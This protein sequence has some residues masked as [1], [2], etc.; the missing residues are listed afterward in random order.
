LA[1]RFTAPD[2][3]AT[4]DR[5]TVSRGVFADGLTTAI[6]GF[7]GTTLVEP[8][9]WTWQFDPVDPRRAELQSSWAV[10]G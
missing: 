2:S 4:Q 5:W 10:D 7:L 9:L 3:K 1:W 6:A 8:F